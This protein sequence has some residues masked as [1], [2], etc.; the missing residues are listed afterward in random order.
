MGDP[1]VR[2]RGVRPIARS[3]GRPAKRLQSAVSL[4]QRLTEA[5]TLDQLRLTPDQIAFLDTCADGH[6]PRNAQSAIA[7][8]KLKLD[9]TTRKPKQEFEVVETTNAQDITDEEWERLAA[10]QHEVR[11]G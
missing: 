6:P 3:T 4:A 1:K 5:Q 7:A 10:L 8:I 2:G 9:F 11:R